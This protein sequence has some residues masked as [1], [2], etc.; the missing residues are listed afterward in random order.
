M[1]DGLESAAS[2]VMGEGYASDVERR[3]VLRNLIRIV[4]EGE[5]SIGIDDKTLLSTGLGRSAVVL[6]Y[7]A[8][9]TPPYWHGGVLVR[10][11]TLRRRPPAPGPS[12]TPSWAWSITSV[13]RR[14][15]SA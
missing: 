5:F 8:G 9:G 6:A 14:N 2:F 7:Q 3:G 12:S 15:A 10:L 4:D 11:Q 13:I 1:D